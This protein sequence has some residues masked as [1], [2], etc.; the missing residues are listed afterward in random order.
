MPRIYLEGH[1]R[2]YVL[3]SLKT[4]NLNNLGEVGIETLLMPGWSLLC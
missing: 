4:L 2:L 3:W 1:T